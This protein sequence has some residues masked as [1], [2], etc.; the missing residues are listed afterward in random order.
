LSLSRK[1]RRWVSLA[2]VAGATLLLVAIWALW[3]WRFRASPDPARASHEG[4]SGAH[5]DRSASRTAAASATPVRRRW[6]KDEVPMPGCWPALRDFD[7]SA[8]LEDLR[9]AIAAVGGQDPLLAGYLEERLTEMI[10]S[11]PERARMVLGWAKEAS[12]PEL[13]VLLGALKNAP[14]VRDPTIAGALLAMG[15]DEA[16]SVDT[17]S[18]ALDALETQHRL[19]D[20]MM[21]RMKAIALDE[22]SDAAAWM[23]TRSLGRVMKEDFERTGTYQPYW[24]QLLAIGRESEET[25]VQLLAL[26]M[27]S[28]ADPVLDGGSIDALA[29]L[30]RSDPDRNVREMAA[31][32]LSVTRAPDKVLAIFR[33]AFP[34]ER[35]ECVRWAIFRFAARVAGA[36]AL[37]LLAELAAIDPRFRPDHDD[38]A[39]LYASGTVDFA[40][41]WTGKAERHQCLV[42]EGM[43]P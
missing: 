21:G 14:A 28:Y 1:H 30:L 19:D 9:A 34:L 40:R 4:P 24:R 26:E 23:A 31:H 10:G 15:E 36:G 16:A 37:P 8:S 7:R 17:R 5:V 12:G 6:E 39:A 41:I 42:E 11:D 33:A 18:R 27:P 13:E 38:F 32:R 29:E 22:T 35:D 43:E 25:A 3:S 2:S 20:G